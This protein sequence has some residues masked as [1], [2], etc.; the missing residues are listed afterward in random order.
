LFQSL[1]IGI[2]ITRVRMAD[3]DQDQ[4]TEQPTEKRLSDAME[5]GQFAH[6]ADLSVLFLL[7]AVLGA[8]GL[9]TREASQVVA[10]YAVGIFTR[11]GSTTLS[12]DTARAELSG[13]MLASSHALTPL[14]LA[15]TRS[16]A[17]AASSTSRP[18]SKPASIFSS[19][20]ASA[21]RSTS[22][23]AA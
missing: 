16:R 11:F 7:A 6:S 2:A 14:L 12:Y 9:T 20:W 13:M 1:G 4:K 15:W 21:P 5:R 22:A 8:L 3:T 10:E 19:S 23:R 18:L 17:S